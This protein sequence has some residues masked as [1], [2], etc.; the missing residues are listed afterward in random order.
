VTTEICSAEPVLS[1]EDLEHF[2]TQGYVKLA[3]AVPPEQ[4]AAAVDAIWQFLGMDRNDPED[5]YRP[6]HSPDGIVEIYQHQALWDNRQSP[7]IY[8]AFRQL[9][10]TEKLWISLDRACMKPPMNSRRDDWKWPSFMHWDFD[11]KETPAQFG[12]QGVL[13]LSDTSEDQGGFHCIP[14]MHREVIEWSNKPPEQREPKVLPFESSRVRAIPANAGDLIMWHRALPHGSGLNR[15]DRPRLAQYILA[16]PAG[17]NIS[18]YQPD[19]GGPRSATS[20]DEATR[21]QRIAQWERRSGPSGLA[22]DPREAGPP[23][24]LTPLGRRLLGLDPWA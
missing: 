20:A 9:W 12:V 7:R 13:C 10:Q 21:Q 11:L 1:A 18:M 22:L 16:A 4:A 17:F 6:P 3:Q 5:W 2:E 15:T 24:V 23:A 8:R 19:D 14:G